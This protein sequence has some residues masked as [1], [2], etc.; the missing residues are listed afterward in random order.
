M[1]VI[2]PVYNCDRFLGEAIDSV[3]IQTYQDYEIIVI[4]DGSTDQTCQV[5]EPYRNKIQY[6]Y[7]E[8]QGSAVA[9]NLGIK[10]ARGELIAFLDAD[11]F[12]LLPEKLG[13]QVNCFEQQ[14]SL[15]SVH[16]GWRIVDEAGD[17]II[18]VEPWGDVPNLNLES[19]L[20]YKPVKTSGMMI[21]QDW[22]EKVGGFDGELRQSHDVDLVLRLA[23]MGCAAA[24]WRRVAV[25]YRRYQGNT[26]RNTQT[27]AKCLLKVLDKF[28]SHRDLP[29][30]I[31]QMESQVRYHTLVWIAWYQY[32]QGFYGEMA[33]FLKRSL[34]YT[35]YYK[36][37]TISDWVEQFKKFSVQNRL[38]LDIC[39]L[40]DLPEWQQ[41]IFKI[42]A[43]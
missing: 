2:I 36:V 19:W 22:L 23:L 13:E 5:L 42:R 33:R 20:M 21:R 28:F 24:W 25:G 30:S 34:E 37:E 10:E 14:P 26:T 7:Q 43:I 9:R 12:W 11:D 17:K 41:L 27:Q 32:Y 8:N 16:T 29:A 40:T 18:D 15:G 38:S 4:D 6:F 3:L 1:S 31:Q 39:L 35:P